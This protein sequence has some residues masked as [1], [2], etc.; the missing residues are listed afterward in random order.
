MSFAELVEVWDHLPAGEAAARAWVDPGPKHGT[1]HRQARQEIG[2]LMPLLARALD[3]LVI[4]LDVQ[5]PDWR[6]WEDVAPPIP[7]TRTRRGSTP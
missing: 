4:E 6:L 1:W 2:Y 3:R 5:T 7:R